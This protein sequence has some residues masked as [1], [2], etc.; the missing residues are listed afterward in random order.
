MPSIDGELDRG[1]KPISPSWEGDVVCVIPLKGIVQQL[2]IRVGVRPDDRF[3][4]LLCQ[5]TSSGFGVQSCLGNR[6]GLGT[7]DLYR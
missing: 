1:L 2:D 7:H 5:W 6:G 4:N 3:D